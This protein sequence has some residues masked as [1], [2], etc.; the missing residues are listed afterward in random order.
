MKNDSPGV[1]ANRLGISRK[2]KPGRGQSSSTMTLEQLLDL[3]VAAYWRNRPS[4]TKG[5]A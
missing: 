2:G 1:V 3:A 5:A 4:H